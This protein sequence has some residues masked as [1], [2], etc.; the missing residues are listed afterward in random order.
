MQVPRRPGCPGTFP[1][2]TRRKRCGRSQIGMYLRVRERGAKAGG[3]TKTNTIRCVRE[4]KAT[5]R[6]SRTVKK[7]GGYTGRHGGGLFLNNLRDPPSFPFFVVNGSTLRWGASTH[8]HRNKRRHRHT[9]TYAQHF[10]PFESYLED[11]RCICAAGFFHTYTSA[12]KC[13]CC[14]QKRGRILFWNNRCVCCIA[15][16]HNSWNCPRGVRRSQAPQC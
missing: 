10:A 2:N 11:T 1:W 8:S 14:I 6:T 3:V 12:C 15:P 9:H 16:F 4:V 5:A 13:I 7:R